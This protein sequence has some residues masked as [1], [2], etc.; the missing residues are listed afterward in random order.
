MMF[1]YH[2]PQSGK[3]LMREFMKKLANLQN[4]VSILRSEISPEPH[5]LVLPSH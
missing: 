1:P 5:G 3:D 2:P 4:E